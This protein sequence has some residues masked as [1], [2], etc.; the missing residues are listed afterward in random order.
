MAYKQLMPMVVLLPQSCFLSTIRQV[1]FYISFFFIASRSISGVQVEITPTNVSCWNS[2]TGSLLLQASGGTGGGYTYKVN[3]TTV[4]NTNIIAL[5][6]GY[7]AI[8]VRDSN[9]CHLAASQTIFQPSGTNITK[10][11]FFSSF[12]S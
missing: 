3:G 8:E 7:Y 4:T 2:S 12:Y 5:F 9:G 10:L 1:R 6:A 11:S